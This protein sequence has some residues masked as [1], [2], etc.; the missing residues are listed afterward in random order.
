MPNPPA[1]G[2]IYS[3]TPKAPSL[4]M[5]L[6]F[7]TPH[8]PSLHWDMLAGAVH[9]VVNSTGT[10]SC[11]APLTPSCLFG[12]GQALPHLL[13]APAPLHLAVPVAVLMLV[14]LFLLN[15]LIVGVIRAAVCVL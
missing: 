3:P 9:A 4:P 12:A 10:R 5:A 2:G 14:M 1:P 11:P 6:T 8:R 7:Q 15:Q 13:S